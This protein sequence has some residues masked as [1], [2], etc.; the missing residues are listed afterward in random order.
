M[1][2]FCFWVSLKCWIYFSF[3]LSLMQA[4]AVCRRGKADLKTVQPSFSQTFDSESFPVI[5]EVLRL[6]WHLH[7]LLCRKWVTCCIQLMTVSTEAPLIYFSITK[8]RAWYLG[9]HSLLSLVAE[10]PFQPAEADQAA[11][12]LRQLIQLLLPEQGTN[13]IDTWWS[14]QKVTYL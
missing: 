10:S 9:F 2:L 6:L 1:L 4:S 14:K 7:K 8:S 13:P 12:N 3:D 5:G 11:G